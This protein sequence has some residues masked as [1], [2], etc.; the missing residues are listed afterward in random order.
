MHHLQTCDDEGKDEAKVGNIERE[1]WLMDA[2]F[3]FML[4]IY[5]RRCS[6]WPTN[7]LPVCLSFGLDRNDS[8]EWTGGAAEDNSTSRCGDFVWWIGHMCEE[9]VHCL[10]GTSFFSGTF[11]VTFPQLASHLFMV[12]S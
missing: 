7:C 6:C 5:R 8:A 1:D 11:C 2:S 9:V 12:W 3:F 10:R 4:K